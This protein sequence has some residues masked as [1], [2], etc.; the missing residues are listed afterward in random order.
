MTQENELDSAQF[1][2]AVS[3]CGLC[4]HG[5]SHLCAWHSAEQRSAKCDGAEQQNSAMQ[6][7][8]RTAR[9]LTL[10]STHLGCARM[11]ARTCAT[12]Q[13]IWAMRAERRMLQQQSRL[14]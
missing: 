4:A 5:G 3:A 10:L 1:N 9:S 14:P 13:R 2:A 8:R 6:L 12:A 11:E 7:S